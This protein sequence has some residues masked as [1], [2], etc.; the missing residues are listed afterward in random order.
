MNNQLIANFLKHKIVYNKEIEKYE[1]FKNKENI[2]KLYEEQ[3]WELLIHILEKIELL[4]YRVEIFDTQCLIKAI[5]DNKEN[6]IWEFEQS[7]REAVYNAI[8]KFINIYN[9]RIKK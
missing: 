4:S 5:W 8:I 7:K 2:T 1:F 3:N 9:D 6:I